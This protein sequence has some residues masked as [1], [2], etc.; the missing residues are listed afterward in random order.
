ME[1]IVVV[2]MSE[3]MKRFRFKEN[4]SCG[5][6]DEVRNA[7]LRL[8]DLGYPVA[9]IKYH[10][11]APFGIVMKSKTEAVIIR[12]DMSGVVFS[13]RSWEKGEL[14]LVTN[15]DGAPYL[16]LG[17]L[18]DVEDTLIYRGLCWIYEGNP[19]TVKLCFLLNKRK[20]LPLLR[21][22]PRIIKQSEQLTCAA[23]EKVLHSV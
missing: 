21:N 10:V 22:M 12:G 8:K 1:K 19:A 13:N 9:Q 16:C 2:G 11:E 3:E 18:A 20:Q 23:I 4:I 7:L 14:T 15:L 17:G 5:D 6:V